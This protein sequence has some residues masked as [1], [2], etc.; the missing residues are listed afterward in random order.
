MKGVGKNLD[1]DELSFLANI[2]FFVITIMR[3]KKLS[4]EIYLEIYSNVT[5][6]SP[7]SEEKRHLMACGFSV[8]TLPVSLHRR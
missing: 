4:S 5:F 3:T 6:V 8:R 1:E 2:C 7:E